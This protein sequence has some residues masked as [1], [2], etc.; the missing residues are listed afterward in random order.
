MPLDALAHLGTLLIGWQA[1]S[2]G[3]AGWLKALLGWLMTIAAVS[4][5]APF[6]FDLLGKVAHL[7]GAGHPT[8]R[9]DTPFGTRG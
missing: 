6:W 3:V 9:N 2:H 7:R 8:G 1:A 5:G 4:L